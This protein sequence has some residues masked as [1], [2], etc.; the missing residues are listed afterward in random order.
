MLSNLKNIEHV[1]P[2]DTYL[3]LLIISILFLHHILTNK[4]K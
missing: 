3:S 1:E 2:N 4:A